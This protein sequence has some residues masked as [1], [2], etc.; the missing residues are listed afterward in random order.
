[1]AKK[2]LD[3]QPVIKT[4]EEWRAAKFPTKYFQGRRE[5]ITGLPSIDYSQ[6]KSWLFESAKALKGWLNGEY[7]SEE[8]FD[9]GIKET[10]T[11]SAK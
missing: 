1:M 11:H 6:D 4:I 5:A 2:E 9:K 8:Q 7:V 10:E 3:V